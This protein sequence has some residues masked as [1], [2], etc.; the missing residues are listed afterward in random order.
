MNWIKWFVKI[1]LT[2]IIYYFVILLLFFVLFFSFAPMYDFILLYFLFDSLL[3]LFVLLCV[4]LFITIFGYTL[5]CLYNQVYFFIPLFNL[6]MIN[7]RSWLLMDWVALWLYRFLFLCIYKS[8]FF[9]F[10]IRYLNFSFY[11]LK[12]RKY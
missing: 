2:L 5:L 9:S 1:I 4:V 12:I 10:H 7:G 11:F 8:F 6:R 3:W